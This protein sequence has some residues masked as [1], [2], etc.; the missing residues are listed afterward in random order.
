MPTDSVDDVSTIAALDDPVRRALYRHIATQ[1]DAVNR[2]QA[3]RAA[4]ISRALAAYH[5]DRLAESGLLEVD[6][7]RP[8]GRSG[9]GAGRPTKLY[10]RSTRSVQVSFP[11]RNYELVAKLLL[12]ALLL[13]IGVNVQ[14]WKEQAR[15]A[16]ISSPAT[17]QWQ[18]ESV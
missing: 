7:R 8:P 9:P 3:A 4:N 10:R 18:Q 15:A 11:P 5:L 17:K 16:G 1:P 12:T 6:Y 14:R 2:D 13:V